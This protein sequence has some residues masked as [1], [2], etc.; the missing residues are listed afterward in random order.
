MMNREYSVSI[1]ATNWVSV[2]ASSEE[3]A[4]Q[5]ALSLGVFETLDGADYNVVSISGPVDQP[6]PEPPKTKS[7]RIRFTRTET[8]TRDIEIGEELFDQNY[9]EEDLCRDIYYQLREEDDL[10]VGQI[11]DDCDEKVELVKEEDQT[12]TIRDIESGELYEMTVR[13]IL[14]ELN[15]DRVDSEGVLKPGIWG[16]YDETDWRDGL[17]DNGTYEVVED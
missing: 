5:K 9:N 14:D 3:E 12:Y 2:K 8:F 16:L 10:F 6:P 7:V 15:R 11:P 17:A 4:E 1:V 13:M